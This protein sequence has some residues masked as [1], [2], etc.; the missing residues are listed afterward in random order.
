MAI[1]RLKII[2]FSSLKLSDNIRKK[3]ILQKFHALHSHMI[4]NQ[5]MHFL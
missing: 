4:G 1:Q 2:L 3:I 5:I